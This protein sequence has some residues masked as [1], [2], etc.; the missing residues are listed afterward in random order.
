MAYPNAEV[1][2]LF[3]E[4]SKPRA[5]GS[6]FWFE[7]TTAWSYQTPIAKLVDTPEG[8]IMLLSSRKF[9]VTTSQHQSFLQMAA[10][11]HRM[12]TIMVDNPVAACKADHDANLY[13]FADKGKTFYARA[14]NRRVHLRN[15][16]HAIQSAAT[17][18]AE[19][20][21]YRV[22]VLHEPLEPLS[23]SFYMDML[24]EDDPQF[25][26]RV[27]CEQGSCDG[28]LLTAVCD[29]FSSLR[30]AVDYLMIDTDDEQGRLNFA[31]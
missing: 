23:N 29:T 1:A 20:R 31:A 15:R 14:T 3:A 19:E 12:V 21:A 4:Q 18:L 6:N 26:G 2:E 25:I 27:A 13:E 24:L 17:V 16:V 8:R 9:S 30:N 22:L 7:G 10:S 5:R 28:L 11:R